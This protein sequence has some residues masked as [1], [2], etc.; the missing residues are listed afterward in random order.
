[1]FPSLAQCSYVVCVIVAGLWWGYNVGLAVQNICLIL[2]VAQ[3]NWQK[4]AH[5]VS[6][7]FSSSRISLQNNAELCI[8]SSKCSNVLNKHIK[9]AS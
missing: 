4:E 5:N 9:C 6:F 1:M 8:F 2:F 3:L 7:S